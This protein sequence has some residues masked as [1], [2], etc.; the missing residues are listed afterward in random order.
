MKIVSAATTFAGRPFTDYTL[1]YT[2]DGTVP[3]ADSPECRP[4][5]RNDPQL[6]VAVVVKGKVVAGVK[7]STFASV[8][9]DPNLR[10][11]A[12]NAASD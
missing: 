8:L 3:T 5:L 11:A 2:T 7:A 12:L 9:L 4:A 6:R 10:H 1:R